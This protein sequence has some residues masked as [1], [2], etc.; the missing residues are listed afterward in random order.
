MEGRT[1]TQQQEENPCCSKAPPFPSQGIFAWRA[2]AYASRWD[3]AAHCM[4]TAVGSR[5]WSS[6]PSKFT[7]TLHGWP[8][9]VDVGNGKSISLGPW[10]TT[11]GLD[12]QR[13]VGRHDQSPGD[14]VAKMCCYVFCMGAF[15]QRSG[16]QS[17][18]L[19]GRLGV[20]AVSPLV[21]RK[22]QC[23]SHGESGSAGIADSR[24]SVPHVALPRHLVG[25]RGEVRSRLKITFESRE[26]CS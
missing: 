14:L 11:K 25:I 7:A 2:W 19:S 18:V 24:M 17:I 6:R 20:V 16:G 12:Q 26:G 23:R 3:M 13:E 10:L 1:G 21:T 22:M 15:D 9:T 4:I 5:P 8:H